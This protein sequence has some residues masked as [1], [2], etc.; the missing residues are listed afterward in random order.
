MADHSTKVSA[1]QNQSAITLQNMPVTK[2][3]IRE[4]VSLICLEHRAEQTEEL[5]K[6]Y[7]LGLLDLTMGQ[8]ARLPG[9]I[10]K[11]AEV[12]PNPPRLRRLL[13]IPTAEEREANQA[14]AALTTVLD[15]LAGKGEKP[16]LVY[17]DA[18][19]RVWIRFVMKQPLDRAKATLEQFGSGSIEAGVE[20]LCLHPRFR[21]AG[22]ERDGAG[23]E[24]SAIQKIEAR[25]LQCWRNQGE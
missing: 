10:L 15:I 5:D 22:D 16:S 7:Y 6:M 9:L 14:A 8:L 13:G 4:L 1:P 19:R 25:W 3:A 23:Y 17:D 24:L 12:W 18:K 11:E 20:L 2:K 21:R